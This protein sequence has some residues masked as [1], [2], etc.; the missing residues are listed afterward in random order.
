MALFYF[1]TTLLLAEVYPG[2]KDVPLPTTTLIYMT[3]TFDIVTFINLTMNQQI[4]KCFT[5]L[6]E[7]EKKL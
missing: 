3:T 6:I 2:T 1:R 7:T 5:R 4:E